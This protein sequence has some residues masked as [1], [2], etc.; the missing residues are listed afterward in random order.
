MLAAP[1]AAALLV[2]DGG[3]TSGGLS[4]GWMVYSDGHSIVS[5]NPFHYSAVGRGSS[6]CA[7][8]DVQLNA[9]APYPYAGMNSTFSPRDLSSYEGIRF[10]AKGGGVW[11]CQLPIPAT[12]AE[13]NHYSAPLVLTGDWKYFQIP[14]S[15]FTQTWGTKKPWDPAA[16][17]GVQ[18]SAAG[19][20]GDRS[21]IALDSIEFYQKTEA[22]PSTVH[23]PIVEEP[24]VNEEGYLPDG[25]KYF[26]ISDAGAVKKGDLFQILE[27]SGQLAYSGTLDRDPIDDSQASGE[28]VFQVDFSGLT[29]T[30]RYTV[31]VDGLKS[32]PFELKPDLYQS[33]FRDALRCFYLIR[34]GTA[35]DDPVT[36]LKHAACHRSDAPAPE[37]RS[38][39][40][41][42]TGGWHN[43]CDYGKW[44]HME[45]ISCSWMMWL[46]E[47]KPQAMASLQNHIPESGNG[48]SDLLNEARWGLTWL[49]KM[50][51]PDGSVFH[52]VDSRDHF[53]VGT[54]PEKDPFPRYV[55]PGGSLDAGDFVGVM[56]QASR[57]FRQVDPAFSQRCLAAA[58][59]SWEWLGKNP[60]VA[61]EDPDYADA[62]PGQEELWALGEMARA[63]ESQSLRNRFEIQSQ[64]VPLKTVSWMTPQFFGY[65]A[66]YFDEGAAPEEK[67]NIEQALAAIG[68]DLAQKAGSGGYGVCVTADEYY[69]G[70]NENILNKAAALLF[71]YHMTGNGKYKDAALR[72]MNYLLGLNSLNLS[73]VTGHGARAESHPHHWDY[74]SLG[75]VMPG[76]PGGGANHYPQGADPILVDLINRGTPPAKCFFDGPGGTSWASNEGQTSETAALVFCAGYLAGD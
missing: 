74:A 48:V 70:S 71:A 46:Y 11:N 12:N 57:V 54:V 60:A 37:D 24:K 17:T 69:W 4:Q 14:F 13:F 16:V 72:Q 61:V 34:C 76:W 62:D 47:L 10:W 63:T 43:A 68:D 55:L 40:L 39:T 22:F 3:G 1:T 36:G 53:C 45:A 21:W 56:A 38:A 59:L 15:R 7:R 52:K 25:E 18:F 9:G 8:I 6:S 49:L 51:R 5:P 20:A 26:A 42:L 66:Q 30:G 2:D 35:I 27:P 65:M 31:E 29:L 73:F 28:R 19:G 67:E 23:N 33:L 32:V 50:Q 44:T 58:K 64:S 75:I 41:D